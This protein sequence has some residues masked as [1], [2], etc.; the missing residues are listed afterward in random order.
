VNT[1]AQGPGR[2]HIRG[3]TA[4]GSV[5]EEGWC[6]RVIQPSRKEAMQPNRTATSAFAGTDGPGKALWQGGVCVGGG[7]GRGRIRIQGSGR[8]GGGRGS[9]RAACGKAGLV[10]GR[11]CKNDHLEFMMTLIIYLL[12]EP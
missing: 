3:L 12:T 5:W 2:G 1:G 4:S 6:P 11:L 8:R 9:A 10:V 7:A